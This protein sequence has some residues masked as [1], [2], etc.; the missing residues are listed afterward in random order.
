MTDWSRSVGSRQY[1]N[2]WTIWSNSRFGSLLSC[3]ATCAEIPTKSPYSG[4]DMKNSKLSTSICSYV[5]DSERIQDTDMV[6]T[7]Y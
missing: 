3:Y 1:S 7:G 4:S 2:L 5:Y 6:T